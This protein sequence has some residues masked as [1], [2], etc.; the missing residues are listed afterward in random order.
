MNLYFNINSSLV[1]RILMPYN[2]PKNV[3]KKK[4]LNK[5]TKLGKMAYKNEN[6]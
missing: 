4:K 3:L 2:D 6:N 5:M 1:M